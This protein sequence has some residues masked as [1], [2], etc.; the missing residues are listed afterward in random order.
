MT[1]VTVPRLSKAPFFIGDV[2]LLGTAVF[3]YSQSTKPLNLGQLLLVCGSVALAAVL[4]ILPFIV[5]YRAIIRFAETER[6]TDVMGQI[7][8]LEAIGSKITTA[9]GQWQA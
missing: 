7:A 4:S 2:V 5:E 1:E 3:V 9:T 6:L 8:N